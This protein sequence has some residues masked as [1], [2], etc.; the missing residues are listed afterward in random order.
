QSFYNLKIKK[1][2]ISEFNHFYLLGIIN[3]MLL[4]YFFIKSFGT[5]KKLF[6]R[7]LIE[8]IEEFPIKIP[9]SDKCRQKAKKI[10]ELVK[11]ILNNFNYMKLLQKKLDDLVFDL[12]EIS[13]SNR[14]YILNYIEALNN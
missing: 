6:P 10:I 9:V 13:E 1:S 11:K 8:K 7:I 5:Y 3:S 4:S 12:Y 2:P 14:K